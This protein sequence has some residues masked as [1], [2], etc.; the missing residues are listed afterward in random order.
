MTKRFLMAFVILAL[1]FA[2]ISGIS[3]TTKAAYD[4]TSQACSAAG[5]V[6]SPAC[7]SPNTDPISGT[8]GVINTAATIIAWAGGVIA[9]IIMIISGFRFIN[10]G[11]D[12]GKVAS[13]RN[14]IIYAAIGL[15]VIIVARVIVSFV[16]N[17]I[18]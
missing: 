2:L 3:L 10:S 17:N 16:L 8:N 12:S 6:N 14:G 18:K 4:P 9:I 13:A 7:T 1:N 5:Q 11:G 15:L